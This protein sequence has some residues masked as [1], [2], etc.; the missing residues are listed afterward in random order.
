[1]AEVQLSNITKRFAGE[2]GVAGLNLTIADGELVA[3]LGPTG[4]GKT[5]T[6]RVIAG[7]ERPEEGTVLID[8]VDVTQTPPADR[9]IAM[10]FQE[11][12]LYPHFSVYD[13]L[14]FPLRSPLR[15]MPEA[16]IREKIQ[17]IAELL[18]IET[19]LQNKGTKL[20]GGEMQRVSIGRALVR[21]PAAF[22]M[23][24]PLSSLDAKLRD[25]LRVELKRIQIDL[26][27]TIC[28][29][30]HDQ[31]EAMT[32]ADRIGVLS[33][34]RLLQ[35]GTP[36]EIYQAPINTY[37]AHRLGSPSINLFPAGALGINSTP[38]GTHSIGIRPENI[39]VGNSGTATTIRNVEHLGVETVMHLSVD[40]F[41]ITALAP[42]GEYFTK[43]Q[44]VSIS[45]IPGKVL[46]FD[47]AGERIP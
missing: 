4:A 10:V 32:L 18:K 36:A 15:R 3:L 20:S 30:T 33:E 6:L 16:Q 7:L 13:N 28:Y 21:Q 17:Q 19:K 14:A 5:T 44:Q 24:E 25:D 37:V 12:S 39:I 38:P 2:T 1:M 34:G 8:Q 47:Q 46:Y 29:V 42:P 43:G 40:G 26:N 27:A 35:V 41:D 31:V 22:L 23:D 9:D 45:T 11:Y